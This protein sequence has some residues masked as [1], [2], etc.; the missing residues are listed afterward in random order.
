MLSSRFRLL[1]LRLLF[2]CFVLASLFPSRSAAADDQW[3]PVNPADLALKDNP[4]SPGSDAMI[5]YRQEHTD[6]S[7]AFFIEY[8]RIKIFTE[9]GKKWG[10]VEI[11]FLKGRAAI[12][13]IRARTIR[14]DGS[15]V[16]F[17]GQVFEKEIVKTG[18][19]KVLEKT[20]TMP[21]VQPGCIVE[22]KYRV[23]YDADYY[24]D[25]SWNIQEDL[26]TRDAD[27]SI[28]PPEG[29][30]APSIF[31]R[32]FGMPGQ[33]KP[34]KQKNGDYAVE[35]HNIAGLTEEDYM[36]PKDML[37][38]RVEFFFKSPYDAPQTAAQYWK[39][40]DKK[41][42]SSVDSY[43]NK[44][45][46]LQ[47]VVAQATAPTD[48]PEV[49]L[50]K[51]Y[52]RVQAIR[53]LSY[54]D[55]TTQEWKREKLKINNNVEDV[56]KHNYG[57]SREINDVF[58]GLARAAGLEA[59][60]VLLAPR[61]QRFFLPDLQDASELDDDIVRVKL[62]G[63]DLFLDPAAKFYPFGLLPWNETG[64]SGFLINK[65]GGDFIQTPSPKSSDAVVERHATLEIATDGSLSGAV[66]VDFTGIRASSTRQEERTDDET[67]RKKDMGDEI[68]HW[69]PRGAKFEITKMSG[70]ND[71]GPLVISGTLTIPGY[72]TGA[73][74]RMLLPLMPFVAPEGSAFEPAMRV[75]AVYFA[76]PYQQHD[77]IYVKL[78]PG[79]TVESLPQ[80]LPGVTKGAIQY[81]I[82][83]TAHGNTLEVKRSLDVQAIYYS[84]GLYGAVRHVFGMVKTG[85]DEQAV[86]QAP[87]S[88]HQN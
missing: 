47:E 27:F 62:S 7:N 37:R 83:P 48:P 67:G 43:L 8:Y 23:Q 22:Y 58:I 69:F 77:D 32:S 54:D 63:H 11:P 42:N 45:S 35:L 41:I 19:I 6:S 28:R 80:Q 36:L 12:R 2:C 81:S 56:L 72:A 82:A 30:G 16:P 84:V 52:T 33:I 74:H 51:L 57:Y 68:K 46:A 25:A 34:V 76:F 3:L 61:D 70:W 73:G 49:K 78:P 60:Q 38:G 66:E 71:I 5:L 59:N 79:Y 1:M 55:Q 39:E 87:A 18:G 88:A 65:D 26:F 14:P 44:K 85:D 10:D 13:D 24:W 64:V 29:P 53:N 20:F 50:R 31:S 9:A 17:N 4:A 40:Q 21:D 15:I 86:L 75:N